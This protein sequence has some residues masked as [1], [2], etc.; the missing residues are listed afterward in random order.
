MEK[1][2]LGFYCILSSLQLISNGAYGAVYLVR[3][4]ETH[5]RFAMKRMKKQTLIMR[6]QI[7]QVSSSLYKYCILYQGI[8]CCLS[9]LNFMVLDDFQ[10]LGFGC[11]QN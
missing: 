2:L 9:N 8:L 11:F 4:K 10:M 7:N 1:I 3:Q 5:Q 6:N